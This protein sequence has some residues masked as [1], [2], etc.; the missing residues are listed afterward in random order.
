MTDISVGGAAVRLFTIG[1]ALRKSVGVLAGNAALLVIL[2]V[3]LSLPEL[4]FGYV[5]TVPMLE[6]ATTRNPAAI[7]SAMRAFQHLG[8]WLGGL[9]LTMFYLLMMTSGTYGAFLALKAEKVTL[10]ASLRRGLSALL[11]LIGGGLCVVIVAVLVM[12]PPT[13]FMY[14]A[15]RAAWIGAIIILLLAVVFVVLA[16]SFI[17]YVPA[18]VIER[19]G[20]LA[21]FGRSRAL[22]KGRRWSIFG[23]LLLIDIVAFILQL[24]LQLVDRLLFGAMPTGMLLSMYLPRILTNAFVVVFIT[25]VYYYLRAEKE[26]IAVDEMA[27]VF[28]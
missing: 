19:K 7:I 25:V 17:V 18:I 13:A 21:A 9:G 8:P 11:P 24:V 3:G 14:L 27:K 28:D 15:P 12:L 23:A 20:V 5:V 10:G 22:T 2:I 16:I 6:A 4:V 1:H 26:G